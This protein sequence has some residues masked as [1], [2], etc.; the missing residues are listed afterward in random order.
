MKAKRMA[1]MV[2][3]LSLVTGA[4][5]GAGTAPAGAVVGWWKFDDAANPG[6]D[7]SGYGNDLDVAQFQ[8]GVERRVCDTGYATKGC[9]DGSGCLYIDTAGNT[10]SCTAR[11]IWDKTK[12]YTCLMRSRNQGGSI[13]VKPSWLVDDEVSRVTEEISDTTMWHLISV[14]YDDQLVTGGTK[15]HYYWLFGDD[16]MLSVDAGLAQAV[17]EEEGLFPISTAIALGGKIG[18]SSKSM[19]Y[20]GYMDDVAV[21]ARTLSKTEIQ[22]YYHTGDPNPY[23]TGNSSS[24]FN[25]SSS[26]SCSNESLGYGPHNLPGADFQ[27]QNGHVMT[28]GLS[29][30][31][32]TFGGHSL[33][34]GRLADLVSIVDGSMKA[35]KAGNLVQQT[36]V[37]IPDLRL[38][39]G[40]L[41]ASAGMTLAATKLAVNATEANPYEINVAS[42]TYAVTG[43]VSGD[44][45]LK[46]TGAGTLDLTGL[47][48][49]A[50]VVVT[51]GKVLAGPNV[52]VT[53]DLEEDRGAVP[54]LM[55]E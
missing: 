29:Y 52:T 50:K 33:I 55:A 10:A 23:S 28:I 3:A 36:S 20:K 27:V 43:A 44:G 48:G 25:S 54:V 35:T 9:Y 7:S 40:K 31:G 47:T 18:A 41:T 30:A 12:G 26:W 1:M 14:R 6:K 13:Y 8:P 21:V 11:T 45:W 53:Y 22:Y 38:N 24:S 5:W 37:T 17:S 4:A 2:S 15:K 16:P 49:A 39:N 19:S 51:E 32:M 46:K 34:L 42:G